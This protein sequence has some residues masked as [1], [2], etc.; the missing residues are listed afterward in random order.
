MSEEQFGNHIAVSSHEFKQKK[1]TICTRCILPSSIPG[2]RFDAEGVCNFCLQYDAKEKSKPKDYVALEARMV[3]ALQTNP[4]KHQYDCVCLYSGGKDST[5]MLD[6]LVN[7]FKL[8]VLAFTFDN[9]FIPQ[10]TYENINRVL[11]KVECDYINYRPSWKLNK[12]LFGMGFNESHRLEVTKELAYMIGHACWPCF[13]QI[14]L[15]SIKFAVEKNIPNIVVGTTPGQIRQKKYDLVSKFGDLNDVYNSMIK[16]MI[17]LLKLTKQNDVLRALNMPFFQ[18]LKVLGLKLIPFYEYIH[19]NEAEVIR[20][21][22]NKFGW[23]KPKGTDSCS[24]NCQLNALGIEVHRKRYGI[25][26]YVIPLARDV[27]EGLVDRE[28]ALIAV[29]GALNEKLVDYIA[30]RFDIK[31]GE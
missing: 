22:E 10:A 2:I 18:K 21:V 20:T 6:Q 14:A 30:G 9:W 4:K 24:S 5:Y 12:S 28:E 29:N 27:R 25:S 26:P 15:H 31:L 8:R 19:Y 23:S 1:E 3:K 13:V 7:K 11:L 17:E 16:P